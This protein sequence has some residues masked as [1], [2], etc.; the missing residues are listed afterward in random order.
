MTHLTE[1]ICMFYLVAEAEHFFW[2][3]GCHFTD[4]EPSSQK[5]FRDYLFLVYEP[6]SC[7]F[8]F[9]QKLMT[10]SPLCFSLGLP[11]GS[12][13][14]K[15]QFATSISGIFYD[16]SICNLMVVEFPSLS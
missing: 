13:K 3:E 6:C 2:I 8:I 1:P 10:S 9:C 4:S 14:P 12:R 15:D 5:G 11:L 16:P 7:P